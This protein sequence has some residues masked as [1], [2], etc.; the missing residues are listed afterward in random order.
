MTNSEPLPAERGPLI[1]R[2][3]KVTFSP[4]R[5]RGGYDQRA[6]DDFLDSIIGALEGS[7]MAPV[8]SRL[9]EAAFPQTKFKGGYLIEDVDEFLRQLGEVVQRIR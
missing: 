2:I 3:K 7:S 8:S 4:T 9:R 1:A 5:F 6:V